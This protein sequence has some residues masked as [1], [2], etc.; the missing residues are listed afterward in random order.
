MRRES[1]LRDHL[2]GL[3]V[4]LVSHKRKIKE[5]RDFGR[6]SGVLARHVQTR[7]CVRLTRPRSFRAT[8]FA[9]Q[10]VA[11]ELSI[12][13]WAR[14]TKRA[15]RFSQRGFRNRLDYWSTRHANVSGPPTSRVAGIARRTWSLRITSLLESPGR[16]VIKMRP[17]SAA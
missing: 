15:R 13:S 7:N 11:A 6:I 10:R 14:T 12:C 4:E 16:P 8:F 2:T 5:R 3:K 17:L 1:A 9:V